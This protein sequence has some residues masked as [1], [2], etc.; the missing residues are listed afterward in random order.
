[1]YE[2]DV[3]SL[4]FY[5]DDTWEDTCRVVKSL[6]LIYDKRLDRFRHKL[7]IVAW[8]SCMAGEV[9][10]VEKLLNG[11]YVGVNGPVGINEIVWRDVT[12]LGITNSI[13]VAELLI[14]HGAVFKGKGFDCFKHYI[15]RYDPYMIDHFFNHHQFIYTDKYMGL[16]TRY[17]NDPVID[18]INRKRDR[19]RAVITMD[20]LGK[21]FNTNVFTCL[22]IDEYL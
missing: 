20:E 12:F 8:R 10:I 6:P 15:L 16:A 2:D 9:D 11:G 13:E 18:I 5:D 17:N 3:P 21:R 7:Q 14:K 1:M 4:L 19:Q 22:K